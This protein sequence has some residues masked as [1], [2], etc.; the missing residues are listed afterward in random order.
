MAKSQWGQ[1]YLTFRLTFIGL[2]DYQAQNPSANP[3][4]SYNLSSL[5]P[6]LTNILYNLRYDQGYDNMRPE[7]SEFKN[8]AFEN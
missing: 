4:V 8:H 5:P 6:L 2:Y 1:L 7:I 3:T